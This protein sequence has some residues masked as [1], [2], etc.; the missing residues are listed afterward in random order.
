MGVVL[1]D[2]VVGALI[3]RCGCGFAGCCCGCVNR[4][5]WVWFC[6]MLFVSVLIGRCGCGFAGCCCGC[7]NRTWV[8]GLQDVVVGVFNR[9]WVVV[10]RMLLWVC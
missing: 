7:V 10:C 9:M 4:T 5:L 3:G 2:V 1:Q 8:C 6:R